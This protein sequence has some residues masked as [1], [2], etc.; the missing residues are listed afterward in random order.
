M[1]RVLIYF[2]MHIIQ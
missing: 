1:K 2:N